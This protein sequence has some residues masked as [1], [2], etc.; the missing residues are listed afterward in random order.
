M[1]NQENLN[2]LIFRLN[3]I[4]RY[5]NY[6]DWDR[7]FYWKD[8]RSEAV[9]QYVTIHIASFFDNDNRT[10]SLINEKY[11]ET[12]ILDVEKKDEMIDKFNELKSRM[13]HYEKLKKIRNNIIAHTNID[14]FKN[15]KNS[16][17]LNTVQIEFFFRG[18][19]IL[20]NQYVDLSKLDY[21]DEIFKNIEE[22][23]F[24]FKDIIKK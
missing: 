13:P 15:F 21:Y 14:W 9:L 4:I 19:L 5:I 1:E 16:D 6:L 18:I 8:D 22:E 17:K 11:I 20:L 12:I 23:N 7:S 2:F 10:S 3:K 24:S